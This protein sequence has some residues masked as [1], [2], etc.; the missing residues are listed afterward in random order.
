MKK[1]QSVRDLMT[2][3]LGVRTK[4]LTAALNCRSFDILYLAG[5][6]GDDDKKRKGH[7]YFA[8]ANQA[9]RLQ[10]LRAADLGQ[11]LEKSGSWPKL[12][13]LD[14]C[15]SEAF[16][17]ELRDKF[18]AQAA[19]TAM[20]SWSTI[21]RDGA[22]LVFCGAFFSHV[23]ACMRSV[24]VLNACSNEVFDQAFTEGKVAMQ[25]DYELREPS[26][27]DGSDGGRM[28]GGVPVY[29]GEVTP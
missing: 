11:K 21:A 24:G 18:S 25:S 5:H 10:A 3:H 20:V 13:Y 22:C 27:D 19:N 23:A 16:A 26:D 14:F 7:V 6:G 1:V 15:E 9:G 28:G 4:D 29:S 17:H 12:I 2:L 8:G